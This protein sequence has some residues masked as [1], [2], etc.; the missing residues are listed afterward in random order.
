MTAAGSQP[1]SGGV[2]GAKARIER[3]RRSITFAEQ[4][5]SL[6]AASRRNAWIVAAAAA[7]VAV[8]EAAALA[9]L[10]PLKTIEPVV[11]TVDR[12][13]GEVDRPVR[14]HEVAEYTADEA[15]AKS[16]LHRFV[17]RRERF[18]RLRAEDD[19]LYVSLFLDGAMKDR[20]LR[21]YRPS[22][23]ESP[24]NLAD[25][26]EVHVEIFSIAFLD[27]GIAS[28]RFRRRI[29]A[30]NAS[31]EVE[32]WTATV[33]FAFRPARMKEGDLWR[34]PLGMQVSA[35]RRDPDVSPE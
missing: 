22:N 10:A 32:H 26:T 24:L 21:F 9:L 31:D 1:A 35:Y 27:P 23:P 13:T 3:D 34:N 8:F 6:T 12:T 5:L 16:F 17:V 11:I 30:P 7:L 25:G 28:V 20:W 14:V 19:F 15:I 2:V 18:Y 29:V 33:S 4:A